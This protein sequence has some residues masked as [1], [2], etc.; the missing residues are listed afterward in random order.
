[1]KHNGMYL[2]LTAMVLVLMLLVSCGSVLAEESVS[3][4]P[5]AESET[6]AALLQVPDF[7]FFV[8]EKGIGKGSC[9][10]YTA[11]SEDSLRL[12]DGN[13]VVN[14]E[15]EIS[16]GGVENGWLM[17]RC[18]IKDKKARV[19]YIP[20]EYSKRLKANTSKTAFVSIPV[21]L[22]AGIDITDNPRSN[23][24][25]FGSLPKGTEVTIL[26]KYTYTGNWWYV[27]TKLNDRLTRGFINRSE[28]A[29]KI[30]GKVYTGNDELG[31]PAVSPMNTT[32]VGMITVQGKEDDAMIVRKRSNINATMVARVYGGETFPCYGEEMG[33]N[34]RP[35]Y[36]IW[37]DGVWGWF[38]SGIAT[39]SADE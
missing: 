20:P 13:A 28:A 3:S 6:V 21:K 14:V 9:P 16:V 1:M 4:C 38:S 27:E 17:V 8:R 26:G 37:V 33:A 5:A 30:D 7:K 23:S 12:A 25:P 31:F 18:E 2:R 19:G 39:F 29:L 24:T 10:V 15:T 36:Y 11:P 22:A 32:K 34:D 35:W